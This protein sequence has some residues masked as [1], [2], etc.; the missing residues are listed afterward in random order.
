MV[1]ASCSK[2]VFHLC[3]NYECFVLLLYVY[4]E[5]TSKELDWIACFSL[6]FFFY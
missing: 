4:L 5:M 1:D 3:V 2:F 6:P